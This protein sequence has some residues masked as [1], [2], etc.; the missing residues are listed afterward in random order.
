MEYKE[1]R[2]DLLTRI[3]NMMC[4]NDEESFV[5]ER[6]KFIVYY[7]MKAGYELFVRYLIRNW[8]GTNE[9]P[10]KLS[11][12]IWTKCSD[13]DNCDLH[14]TNNLIE[15]FHKNI[16][17][18][19]S[20]KPNLKRFIEILQDIEEDFFAKKQRL[21]NTIE[22]LPGSNPSK[23]HNTCHSEQ[24]A[25]KQ[26]TQNIQTTTTTTQSTLLCPTMIPQ[27]MPN[28]TSLPFLVPL[29]LPSPIQALS[30]PSAHRATQEQ[31]KGVFHNILN[32]K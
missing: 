10:A 18:K 30:Q 22:L 16:N 1:N 27:L 7:K 14:M 31:Q 32:R 21:E 11:Y 25:K 12:K 13:P 4:C 17:S 9:K 5:E 28:S 19:F 20:S 23:H 29:L 8:L 3:N 24:P 26:R 15:L 2:I 6:T